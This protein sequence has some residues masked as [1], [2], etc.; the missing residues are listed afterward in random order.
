ML[1]STARNSSAIRTFSRKT[2][3]TTPLS[4]AA[5]CS[6]P[7]S[8]I[9]STPPANRNDA[10]AFLAGQ[11]EYAD[12]EKFPLPVIALLDMNLP[13]KSGLEV[14]QWIRGRPDRKLLTTHILTGSDRAADIASA[15]D[16]GANGYQAKPSGIDEL[17]EMFRSFRAIGRHQIFP[18]LG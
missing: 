7:G 4:C 1:P 13:K 14:L 16:A 9:G 12:R 10:I 2:I 15:V 6:R 17:V 18:S 3:A 8:A 5:P 11:G